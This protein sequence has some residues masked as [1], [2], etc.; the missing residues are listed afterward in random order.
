[1]TERH[2][3]ADY[4]AVTE[5][6]RI[7]IESSEYWLRNNGDLAMLAVTVRRLRARWPG[8][9]I[10]VLTDVP[11]L[12]RAFHPDVEGITVFGTDPWSDPSALTDLVA[13]LGPGVVGPWELGVLRSRVWFR[14]ML[15]AA[16]RR[17]VRW[18]RPPEPNGG[19]PS[20]AVA[21]AP[22]V[23]QPVHPGSAAAVRE[24][25]LLVVLGGGYITDSDAAQTHR[26]VSLME[27]AC[28]HGVPVAMVGQGIGPLEDPAL[29]RRVAEVLPRVDLIALRE[30]R[31]GP[32]ILE[33]MGVSPAHTSVT[34]DDAVELAYSVRS[35]RIGTDLGI[36][37]RDAPYAP[38][39]ASASET[40]GRVVRTSAAERGA[41]LVPLIIAE[42]RSQDRRSTLPVVRGGDSVA[43]PARR[44]VVPE[45]IAE[46]VS[47][48]R[49]LVT[50]AYHLAVFALS[51]GIPVVALSSTLY[52]DDKFL[53]LADMFGGG[54]TPVRLDDPNLESVLERAVR[55]AWVSAGEVREPLRAQARAQIT[56]SRDV[57]ERVSSLIEPAGVGY[58]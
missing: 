38:V 11:L 20:P 32:E 13:R 37:L 24:A 14:Q 23:R 34:G 56:S 55:S 5:S 39:S 7:V 49:V 2:S 53:G 19:D 31:R 36:C 45:R 46:Q 52:Y 15:D 30:R 50:G 33:R 22:P 18:M 43:Q 17:L 25:S 12:L 51:Q 4:P 27:Y 48:C 42:Y 58:R 10:G 40:V 29:C 57:F 47:R 16:R 35:D 26:V 54:L 41:T 1:M 3:S 6:V 9:R 44:Y 21:D 8:A 28:D